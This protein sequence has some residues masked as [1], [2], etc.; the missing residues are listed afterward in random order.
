MKIG[1]LLPRS[2]FHPLLHHD[3]LQGMQAYLQYRQVS[4]ELLTANIEFGTDADMMLEQAEKMLL[5]KQVDVLVVYADQEAVSKIA[6]LAKPLNR[7]VLVVHNGAKYMHDWEPHPTVLSHT[8]NNIIHCRLTG[9]YAADISK[10][11]AVCTSFYDGGYSHNHALVQSYMDNGGNVAYNFVGQYKV[12][13]FNS[14]PLHDFLRTN[15]HVQTLLALFNGDL[16]HCFLQQL[17]DADVTPGLQLFGSPMLLDESLTAVHGALK[18]PFRISGY[19][20][21]I[22]SLHNNAN[23]LLKTQFQSHTGREA[24]LPGMHGWDTAIILEHIFNTANIHHF[25]A[26]DILAALSDVT[27]DSPRGSLCM[28]TATHHMIAPAWLVQTNE[29]F[30]P[31]I[32]GGT[33]NTAQIW[34]E[35]VNEKIQGV[36]SGWINTYLCA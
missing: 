29:A 18:L 4:A 10:N 24:N 2:T 22:S 28:D 8:L 17:Q 27:L 12:K 7:L 11:A 5:E 19:V 36:S 1:A 31:E 30:E 20:P 26:R 16:A 15:A 3:F 6:A 23:Q 21:W 32:I 14:A 34:Q 9:R 35:I 33:D 13:E 25:K